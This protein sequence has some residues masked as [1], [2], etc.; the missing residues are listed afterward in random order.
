MSKK[1]VPKS[2]GED[3]DN[4]AGGLDDHH[5]NAQAPNR[6]AARAVEV[7]PR[8]GGPRVKLCRVL[9]PGKQEE[10]GHKGDEQAGKKC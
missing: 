4:R 8:N 6:M 2:D 9:R 5:R 10:E 7:T 1:S 3:H